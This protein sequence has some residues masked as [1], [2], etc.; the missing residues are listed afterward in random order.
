MAVCELSLNSEILFTAIITPFRRA[1]LFLGSFRKTFTASSPFNM[2]CLE[3]LAFLS[4]ASLQVLCDV[5]CAW[6]LGWAD[7]KFF[8]LCFKVAS[9]HLKEHLVCRDLKG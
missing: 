3:C 2:V 5:F 1:L 4:P 6:C 8:L 7:E 9:Q